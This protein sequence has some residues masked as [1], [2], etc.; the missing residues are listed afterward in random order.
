DIL[1]LHVPLTDDTRKMIGRTEIRM[2]RPGALLINVARGGVLD[3]DALVESLAE[4]HLGGAGLDVFD[5]EPP[6]PRNPLFLRDD[7]VMTPHV[8]G[9]SRAGLLNLAGQAKELFER[10]LSGEPL[11]DAVAPPAM[12]AQKA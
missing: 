8:A 10:V 1:T 6:D 7:V 3:Y 5:S 11:L 4:G 12:A 9:S 2:M